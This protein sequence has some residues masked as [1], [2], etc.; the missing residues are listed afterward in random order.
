MHVIWHCVPETFGSLKYTIALP[1]GLALTVTEVAFGPPAYA[2][3]DP[4]DEVNVTGAFG[5]G[6]VKLLDTR[7]II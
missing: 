6:P 3:K 4:E 1:L 2:C 7:T 5:S